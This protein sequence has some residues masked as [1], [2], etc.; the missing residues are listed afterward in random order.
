MVLFLMK[1]LAT[2]ENVT[3]VQL[4]F[5]DSNCVQ[6]DIVSEGWKCDQANGG[7]ARLR[8]MCSL[9]I[10]LSLSPKMGDSTTGTSRRVRIDHSMSVIQSLSP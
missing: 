3:E 7:G 10:L 1:S 2:H 4:N 9:T 5:N 6:D 8:K